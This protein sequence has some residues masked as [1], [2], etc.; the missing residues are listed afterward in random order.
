[1]A[2]KVRV[3]ARKHAWHRVKISADRQTDTQTQTQTRARARTHT[4]TDTHTHTHTTQHT[5][6]FGNG[7]IYAHTRVCA[8][9]RK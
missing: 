4:H 1:M 6:V 2:G 8:S 3:H 9:A 7:H 5:P